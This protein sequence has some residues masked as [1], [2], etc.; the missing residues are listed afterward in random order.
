MLILT[1]SIGQQ[2]LVVL[3]VWM[4]CTKNV[5]EVLY[6]PGLINPIVKP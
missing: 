3:F 6:I 1:S 2:Y 5:C 4:Q